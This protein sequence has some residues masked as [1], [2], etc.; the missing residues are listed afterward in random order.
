MHRRNRAADVDPA[1][2]RGG[3]LIL[4]TAG[5]VVLLDRLTKVWAERSFAA[6][7]RDVIEGVLTFR[8][9]TNS[10]GAFSFG[11][12]APLVFAVA[13]IVVCAAI[14]LTAFRGRPTLHAVALGLILGGALGNLLDRILRG[15]GLSGR[16]VDFIDP[17]VWPVFNLADAAVVSGA[18]LLALQS[19]RESRGTPADVTADA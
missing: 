17:H 5:I 2:R 1:R 8:F 16:V 7:P 15:P 12:S 19:F 4:G 9:T 3:L 11:D 13:A 14:A 6:H 10:G 18:V